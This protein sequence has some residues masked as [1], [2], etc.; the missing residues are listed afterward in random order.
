MAQILFPG[1]GAFYNIIK[2]WYGTSPYTDSYGLNLG[3]AL[4]SD[5]DR[6]ITDILRK[7]VLILSNKDGYGYS[8]LMR[9]PPQSTC[10]LSIWTETTI[11][12]SLEPPR[13]RKW[14]DHTKNILKDINGSTCSFDD[15]MSNRVTWIQFALPLQAS[16]N[17]TSLMGLYCNF[18][19]RQSFTFLNFL[20]NLEQTF[21]WEPGILWKHGVKN[22]QSYYR[23]HQ[24]MGDFSQSRGW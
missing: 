21:Y 23:A 19:S 9:S 15:L 3:S 1:I 13:R 12:T 2:S 17:S 18:P 5:Q 7:R 20:R 4:T 22:K 14:L 11:C 24:S 10:Y 16:E 8:C 6:E